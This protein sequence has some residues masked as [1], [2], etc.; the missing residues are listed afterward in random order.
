LGDLILK[1]L[2]IY[3]PS[4]LASYERPIVVPPLGL[5]YIGA[6]LE[7]A[8]HKV[9]ILDTIALNWRTP[10][11]IGNR[12][13]LGQKWGDISD[14]IKRS[15]P[16]AVGISCPFSC[17]SDNAHKVAELVKE[18]DAD[19][20]VIMG[21]AHPSTLPKRVLQDQ[22]VDYV[23]I[24]EGEL[25][26]L[27][28]LKTLSTGAFNEIDGFAYRE[29]GKTVI[30]PKKRFIND[31]DSL[32]FPAR[33][34]LP[35]NEYFN[36]E[37]PHGPELMRKPYTSMITSRGCPF[38]CVFCSIH[39]I[40]GHKWRARS[41]D[42]VVLEIEHLIDVYQIREIHF[43]DDNLTLDK[44]RMEKICDLILDRGLDVRWFT[45][46]GVAIWTLDK[47]LL[48]KMKKSGCY[49]LCFGIESGCPQTL[50]F[51]KKP[52]N[53]TRAR[54]VIHWANDV[55]IWT[56]GF[57]VIGF[58]YETKEAIYE[59]LRFAVESDLD[60]ASFFIA[61]P[62]PGTRLLEIV[63][64]EG[65]IE[66]ALNWADLDVFNATLNTKFFTVEEINSLQRNLY[67]SFLRK[68]ILNGLQPRKFA[69]RL[70]KVRSTEDILFLS[71]L[72]TRF[73]QIIKRK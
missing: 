10:I 58:P 52:I 15:K 56:H 33:H 44:R 21:G 64:K 59:T 65:L 54:Q 51:I 2:L 70:R 3:P 1:V 62:L 61:T 29:E 57:F 69:L 68:R 31:I 17:Q 8:G 12:V 24:G 50:Q 49:K 6:V 67:V 53:L 16:D 26:M 41:A 55:G 18:Y 22:N 11:K 30:N 19:V 7:K 43:E 4:S 46:N 25:T 37:A 38:N 47:N 60:F 45:P 9:E 27:N 34:L 20:P 32:P 23:V 40:W 66:N 39:N 36:A 48:E 5:A 72:L 13:H 42:N 71:R 73:L 28:L 35:M 14:E 63:K